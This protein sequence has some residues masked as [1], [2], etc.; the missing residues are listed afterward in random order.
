MAAQA[1]Q[2]AAALN[3]TETPTDLD[4]QRPKGLF[5]QAVG[6]ALRNNPVAPMVPCHRCVRTDGTI[7]GFSGAVEGANIERKVAILRSEG[8]SVLRS[9]AN[10][11]AVTDGCVLEC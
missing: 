5:A 11:I 2:A 6:Q 9:G 3:G 1:K 4:V 7:G 10:V 8:V